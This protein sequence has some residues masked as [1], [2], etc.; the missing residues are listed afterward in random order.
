VHLV[1][2]GLTLSSSWG[3]GHATLWRGLCRALAGHGH[4]VTFFER[5]RPWYAGHRDLTDPP[6][7][8]LVLYEDWAAA[9]PLAQQALAGADAALVTSYCPD[10]LAAAALLDEAPGAF[11]RAFYDLDTGVTIERARSGLPVEYLGSDGLR[12]Y[13]LVLS[14]SGGEALD[15]LRRRFGARQVAPL[16]G[17][18]DPDVHRPAAAEPRFS[19]DLSYLATWAEDRQAAVDTLF[20]APARRARARRFVLGGSKYPDDFPWTRNLWYVGHVAPPAHPAFYA[21]SRL[22]LNV[23]RSA[24]AGCGWAP[25]GRLFEAAACGVPIVTDRWTGLERFFTPGV[26]ILVADRCEDVLAALAQSD[27]ELSRVGAAARRRALTHH[28]AERRAEELVGHLTTAT[29]GARP[30]RSV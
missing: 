7:A 9:R 15:E 27:A 22:T 8:R 21:S 23:T 30:V 16:H 20:L 26:E 11:V 25:S 6:W 19:G 29:R 24:M 3:N 5:D 2:F 14:Y 10:A 28:T 4:R 13:D 18:V 17:S 12:M 1:V